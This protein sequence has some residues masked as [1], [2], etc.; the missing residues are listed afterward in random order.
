MIRNKKYGAR[1]GFSLIEV[2][3]AIGIVAIGLTAALSMLGFSVRANVISKNRGAA[4]YLA[5]Q[6]LEKFKSWPAYTTLIDDIDDT[7]F[8]TYGISDYQL[9]YSLWEG[10]EDGHGT[11]WFCPAGGNYCEERNLQVSWLTTNF[12]RRTWIVRNGY[13]GTTSYLC[14]GIQFNEAAN[15]ASNINEGHIYSYSAHAALTFKDPGVTQPSMNQSA[16][17]YRK[18]LNYDPQGCS[19]QQNKYRG[20]DF[21]VVRTEVTWRDEFT[22][23]NAHKVVRH[24]FVRP[25]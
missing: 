22:Q 5:N 2:V 19:T 16:R 12:H 8:G 1:G 15:S 14:N 13:T 11:D 3:I 20:A 9:N 18:N 4:I 24:L 6:Q 21:T 7:N 17:I 25:H 23:A 10:G